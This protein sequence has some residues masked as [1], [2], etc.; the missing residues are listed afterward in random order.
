MPGDDV[1]ASPQLN[2]TRAITIDASPEDV[3][4]WLTQMGF[5]KAGWYSYDLVD[6][7]GRQSART[8]HPDWQVDS[9]GDLV[10]GGPI[11]FTVFAL[12]PNRTFCIVVEKSFLVFSLSF[13]LNGEAGRTRLVSRARASARGA[14]G[15][16]F[17]R[18]LLGPGD[19]LMV[20]R[21]L[22]GIKERAE[23]LAAHR[24]D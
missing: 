20:R 14:V 10:P 19:G 9:V 23:A 4:P 3:F 17:V 24:S 11:E 8:L 1:A 12:E 7:L 21:Q 6:N 16:A 22:L 15:G 18:W 13:V 5:G 2:A